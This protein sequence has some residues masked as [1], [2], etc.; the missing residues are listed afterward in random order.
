MKD[1]KSYKVVID[2]KKYNVS[3]QFL[4]GLQIKRNAGVTEQ[5]EQIA[6][7]TYS[8]DN[9]MGWFAFVIRYG[10]TESDDQVMDTEEV[11]LLGEDVKDGIYTAC[12][13]TYIID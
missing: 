13:G 11:D 8:S 5:M 12:N 9:S 4:T 1:Q 6:K 10:T 2:R 3:T 7:A